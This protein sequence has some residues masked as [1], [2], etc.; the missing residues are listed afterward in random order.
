MTQCYTMILY[1]VSQETIFPLK[2]SIS[3]VYSIA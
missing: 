2:I 3:E 1:V